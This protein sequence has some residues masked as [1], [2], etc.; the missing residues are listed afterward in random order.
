MDSKKI[1]KPWKNAPGDWD[2]YYVQSDGKK[3]YL[4]ASLSY[5]EL[6]AV[7]ELLDNPAAR[8]YVIESS[9]TDIK[10]LY[11]YRKVNWNVFEAIKETVAKHCGAYSD[12]PAAENWVLR[13]MQAEMED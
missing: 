7:Q 11:E 8:K 12:F 1:W 3:R 6:E 5:P 10:E 2:L 13:A 4:N 9:K